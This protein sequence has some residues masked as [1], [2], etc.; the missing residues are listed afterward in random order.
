MKKILNL[1]FSKTIKNVLKTKGGKNPKIDTENCP[2]T[3]SKEVNFSGKKKV[4]EILEI[5]TET[6]KS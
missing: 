3:H 1:G 4:K 6:I 2:K 5:V